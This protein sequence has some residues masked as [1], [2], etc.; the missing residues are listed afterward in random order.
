MDGG[1]GG[2]ACFDMERE[3]EAKQIRAFLVEVR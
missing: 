1:A 3:R 2:L